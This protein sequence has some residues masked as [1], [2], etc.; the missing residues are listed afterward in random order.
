M[1][2]QCRED[3][4]ALVAGL[5][6]GEPVLRLP[7]DP[8]VALGLGREGALWARP[9]LIVPKLFLT[10]TRVSTVCFILIPLN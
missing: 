10:A 4:V 5:L 2:L 6:L 9:Q 8:E 1:H 7:V 3:G